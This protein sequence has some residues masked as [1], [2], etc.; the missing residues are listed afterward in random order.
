M[1]SNGL[2]PDPVIKMPSGA[3]VDACW[4]RIGVQGDRSCAQLVQH[5]HCRNC[6]TQSAAARSLLDRPAPDGYLRGWAE[7]LALP[8]PVVDAETCSVVIFRVGTEWFGLPTKSCTEVIGLRPI[9]SLPHRSDGVLLGFAS[10][11]GELVVCISLAVLL[12][13]S[14]PGASGEVQ[15]L[16][17]TKRLLVVGWPEG[18]V[19]LLVDE[20]LSV[21]RHSAEDLKEVPATVAHAQVKFTKAVLPLKERNVGVLDDEL[22]RSAINRSVA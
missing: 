17:A 13:V 5:I 15:A 12:S 6:P 22:L 3:T 21:H 8:A 16:A 2:L 11:R 9:H 18:P 7:Q 20:V 1:A 4:S 19:A 10:V 14:S